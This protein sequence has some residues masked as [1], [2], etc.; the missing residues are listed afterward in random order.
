MDP[1]EEL[2]QRYDVIYHRLNL[3]EKLVR[4]ILIGVYC[5]GFCSLI[6][7]LLG[8]RLWTCCIPIASGVIL[9]VACTILQRMIAKKRY[10]AIN[11]EC[12]EYEELK[13]ETK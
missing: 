11:N 2:A 3:Y 8:M 6:F 1:F 13:G 5:L 10:A 12:K 4:I 7:A 9:I